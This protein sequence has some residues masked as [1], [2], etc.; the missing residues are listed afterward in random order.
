MQKLVRSFTLIT[1][2][3]LSSLFIQ[4]EEKKPSGL[5]TDLIEHTERTWQNG[6]AST[7]RVWDLEAAIE[8][9]QY[10]AIRSTHPAFSWIVPGELPNTRQVAYHLI[11]SDN[12]SDSENGKGNV[13]DSGV[14]N[15]NQ[16][17]RSA[18]LFIL[19]R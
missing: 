10:A 19:W 9:L 6:Y 12:Q 11:V 1:S 15:S 5:M 7:V 17:P 4:A 3:S 14:I 13:W 16:A 18:G 2:L 8:P